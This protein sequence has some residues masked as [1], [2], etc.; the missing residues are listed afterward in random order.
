ENWMEQRRF[1]VTTLREFG[2]GKTLMEE[3][4]RNSAQ[5]LI[6]HIAKQDLSNVDLRWS[7]QVFVANIINEFLFG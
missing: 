4:I 6:D 7:I 1:I 2:V 3:K 5:N